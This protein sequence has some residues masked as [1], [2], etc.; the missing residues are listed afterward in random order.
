MTVA[1]AKAVFA[2][3]LIAASA[4]GA[5]ILALMCV[6]ERKMLCRAFM[7]GPISMLCPWL[8]RVQ[9]CILPSEFGDL[10]LESHGLCRMW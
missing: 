2:A 9:V 3:K 8:G 10:P 5:A 6:E 1:D 7:P 4:V